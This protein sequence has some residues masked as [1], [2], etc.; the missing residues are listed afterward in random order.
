MSAQPLRLPTGN[1]S[2]SVSP[3]AIERHRQR[4]REAYE[5]VPN[6]CGLEGDEEHGPPQV[7]RFGTLRCAQCLE[8]E[9]RFLE[10]KG[11]GLCR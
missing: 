5:P 3:A 11:S 2:P 4:K 9:R 1:E 8:S 10:G 6:R 7:T